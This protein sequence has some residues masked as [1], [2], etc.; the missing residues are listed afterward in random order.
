MTATP[1]LPSWNATPARDAVVAF[2]ESVSRAGGSD[3]VP[4]EERIAVFDNDGTL[5]CEKPLPASS[6][7]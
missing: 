3:Y 2:V 1:W 4:M 5:W 7:A 6:A